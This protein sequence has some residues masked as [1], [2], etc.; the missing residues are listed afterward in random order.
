MTIVA[1]LVA[2]V[3]FAGAQELPLDVMGGSST[4]SDIEIPAAPPD[5]A[6]ERID[7][8]LW[9]YPRGTERLVRDL[10]EHSHDAFS[11]IEGELGAPV[12]RD[13]VIRI[14]R[15]IDG[16][17]A[18]APVG[19]PPPRAATGVAYPSARLI[20][21]TLRAP[22]G[23]SRPPLRHV[24]TH[25]LSH[26][27]L[28]DAVGGR[29]LPR[30]FTEGVAIAHARESS[31]ERTRVLWNATFQ[32]RIIPLA[33]LSRHFGARPHQVTLGYAQSAD[34][35][36]FLRSREGGRAR[37]AAL[38][39]NLRAGSAFSQAVQHAY[40]LSLDELESLW[41]QGLVRRYRTLPFLFSGTTFW[42][43]ATI[44]VVV[45][46]VVRRRRARRKIARW[47]ALEAGEAASHHPPKT[48]LH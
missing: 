15:D 9:Q 2:I 13:L 34:F 5:Y 19:L 24:L 45:A 29:S 32:D 23:W 31:F 22:D 20:V 40:E 3:G 30:W 41:R 28:F 25:E 21:L 37:F 6:S 10:Q 7:Q 11:H 43:F 46:Y 35:V 14:A 39:E 44:L 18:L 47:A 26:I 16:M 4:G 33:D 8:S 48:A 36:T 42:V 1:F 12:S 38:L 27:A 17:A